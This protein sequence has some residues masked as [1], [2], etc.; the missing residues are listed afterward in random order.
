MRKMTLR[1]TFGHLFEEPTPDKPYEDFLWGEKR[2]KGEEDLDDEI[3][4][5]NDFYGVIHGAGMDEISK[6]T[7]DRLVRLR[8]AGTYTD[9]LEVPRKF[10]RALRVIEI[11]AD[12][13][14]SWVDPSLTGLKGVSKVLRGDIEMPMW[15]GHNV[16]S[17]T[18]DPMAAMHMLTEDILPRNQWV[19]VLSVDL[20][21]HRADFIGN[22][23]EMKH[24]SLDY[25]WQAEVWQVRDTICDKIAIVDKSLL[26]SVTA[27]QV[28]AAVYR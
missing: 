21:K 6:D 4:L 19:A 26:T 1:E 5:Y 16:V 17:W 25:A 24:I 14:P 3:D 10:S 28:I 22:P 15:R 7:V 9:V 11:N 27:T 12:N 23:A 2:G 8:D 20:N 13:P 18:V